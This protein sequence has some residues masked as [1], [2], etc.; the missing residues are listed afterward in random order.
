MAGVGPGHEEG[1]TSVQAAEPVQAPASTEG[2]GRHS[3][4]ETTPRT[5]RPPRCPRL[6]PQRQA[7]RTRKPTIP[8]TSSGSWL[9][10]SALVLA[11]LAIPLSA[12]NPRTGRFLNVLV[13]IFLYMIYS[14]LISIFQAWVAKGTIKPALGMFGVHAVMVMLLV[15]LLYRRMFG[16]RLRWR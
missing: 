2:D 6:I 15:L 11:F 4:A 9:P 5:N 13:A 14:N 3:R 1:P 10:L 16:L 12:V 8:A 7:P